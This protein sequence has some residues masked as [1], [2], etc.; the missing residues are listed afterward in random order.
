MCHFG[1][2]WNLM[3]LDIDN[4]KDDV[5]KSMIRFTSEAKFFSFEHKATKKKPSKSMKI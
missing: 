1:S 4:I 5:I 2:F 3:N